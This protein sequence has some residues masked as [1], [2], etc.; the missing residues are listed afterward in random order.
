VKLPQT[1]PC[2][3]LA[4]LLAWDGPDEIPLPPRNPHA[5]D[6]ARA[7]RVAQHPGGSRARSIHAVGQMVKRGQDAK[8]S[9][10]EG[11]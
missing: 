2:Q 5:Q 10:V 7:V 1:A 6:L 4:G 8:A 9:V 11:N 3:E